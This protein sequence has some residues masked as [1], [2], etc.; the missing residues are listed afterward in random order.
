M[1]TDLRQLL[2]RLWRWT[3]RG[4]RERRTEKERAR[5]WAEVQEGQREA[6]ANSRP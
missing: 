5:F 6:E 2:A 4:S 1:W 3:Q